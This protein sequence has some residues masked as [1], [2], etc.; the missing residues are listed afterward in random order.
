MTQPDQVGQIIAYENGEL[1][2]DQTIELFQ[3]LINSGLA[4]SLQGSYGRAARGLIEA[5]HCTCPLSK[6]AK[7]KGN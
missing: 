3:G 2:E 4:W 6:L 1:D 5:G 7:S